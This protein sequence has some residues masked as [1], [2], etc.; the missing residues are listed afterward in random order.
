MGNSGESTRY[1]NSVV[2]HGL[3]SFGLFSGPW[4]GLVGLDR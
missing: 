3:L 4:F 2:K 1:Q